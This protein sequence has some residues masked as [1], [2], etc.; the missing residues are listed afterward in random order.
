MNERPNE[1]ASTADFEFNALREAENYRRAIM[2]LFASHLRGRVIEVG[3]GVGQF[4]ALLRE[5]RQIEHLL[6][7]EPDPKF[8][9]E[10][11]KALPDQPLLE[12][13]IASVTD[14]GP[15]NGILSINVLEHIR[16]DDNEL[17]RYSALLNKKRGVLCLFVPARQEIY[18]PIEVDFGH[19]RRYSRR[20][21]RDKMERAG[22]KIVH[23]HYFNFIGYFAWWL[24]FQVG[25]RRKFNPAMVRLFDRVIFP[26]S[27][28][29]ESRVSWPPIGQSLVAVAE[30]TGG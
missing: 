26:L 2:R 27:F 13:T 30:A 21:L 5:S 16:E 7:I 10:F 29:F 20:G 8:C 3:A 24:N 6:S 18:S 15:W 14:P 17:A 25:R 23:L 22:F 11:R 1:S 19:H 9:A 4:T 28:G 12:G